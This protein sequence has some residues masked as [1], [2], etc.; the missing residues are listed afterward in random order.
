MQLPYLYISDIHGICT[1]APSADSGGLIG[2]RNCMRSVRSTVPYCLGAGHL[3]AYPA[4]CRALIWDFWYTG[5]GEDG[6]RQ[7]TSG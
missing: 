7:Q 3:R 5:A 6:Y 2:R 4:H 1:W